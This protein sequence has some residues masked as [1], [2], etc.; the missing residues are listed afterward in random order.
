MDL[1]T[2]DGRWKGGRYRKGQV[3]LLEHSGL[4]L[5]A[6]EQGQVVLVRADSKKPTEVASFKAL[7][8]KTWNY[9]VVIRGRLYL[10]NSQEAA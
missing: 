4:L 6:A 3:L 10:R 1:K 9:P 8:G 5:V 2:S 7:D